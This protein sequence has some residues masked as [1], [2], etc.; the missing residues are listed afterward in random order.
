MKFARE[1]RDRA[2]KQPPGQARNE[3]L[4]RAYNADQAADLDR[5]L[6]EKH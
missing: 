2:K 1:M 4:K 5:Q 6:R 3:F